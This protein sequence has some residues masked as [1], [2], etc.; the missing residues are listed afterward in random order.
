MFDQIIIINI[1]DTMEST[2]KVEAKKNLGN[3]EFKEGNYQAAIAYYTE[4][5][6]KCSI[7]FLTNNLNRD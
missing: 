1:K 7:Y 4:S 5:I 2:S 6:G 3:A